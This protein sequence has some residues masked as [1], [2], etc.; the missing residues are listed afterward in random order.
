MA[1]ETSDSSRGRLPRGK[2]AFYNR[3][4]WNLVIGCS[5]LFVIIVRIAQFTTPWILLAPIALQLIVF[6][7]RHAGRQMSLKS[8]GYS[9][10]WRIYDHWIYEERQ[11]YAPAALLL[12]VAN[13]EP[14]HYELFIPDEPKWR[15]TVPAWARDRREEIALR[16]AER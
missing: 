14:G 1:D 15:E 5:V 12:P 6:V 3:T 9:A 16:I 13:T 10:G 4:P 2:P 8:K 7:R 11:G